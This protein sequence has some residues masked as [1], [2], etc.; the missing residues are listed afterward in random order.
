MREDVNILYFDLSSR[1]NQSTDRDVA[2]GKPPMEERLYG[3]ISRQEFQT[4]VDD[5][6]GFAFGW[7][8]HPPDDYI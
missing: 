5:G 2:Q 7:A 4:L 8:G 6:Y 1:S 3:E